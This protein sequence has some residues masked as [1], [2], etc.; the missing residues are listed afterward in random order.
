[1]AAAKVTKNMTRKHPSNQDTKRDWSSAPSFDGD[2]NGS[3]VD[4]V[5]DRLPN[6]FNYI[7]NGNDSN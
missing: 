1:M 5:S 3:H 7:S 6:L 2:L 4:S